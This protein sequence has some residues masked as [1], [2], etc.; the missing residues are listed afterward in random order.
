MIV[1]QFSDNTRLFK[2]RW[3]DRM[4]RSEFNA[5]HLVDTCY[6]TAE[7]M[8]WLLNIIKLK[9]NKILLFLLE[10]LSSLGL[11]WVLPETQLSSWVPSLKLNKWVSLEYFEMEWISREMMSHPTEDGFLSRARANRIYFIFRSVAQAVKPPEP[12][13][14][15]T[16]NKKHFSSWLNLLL[17]TFFPLILYLP[18]KFL[19]PSS[20]RCGLAGRDSQNNFCY[21][22]QDWELCG[23][24]SQPICKSWVWFNVF[25]CFL[26]GTLHL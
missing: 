25:S 21:F 18:V 6:P 22:E 9:I 17:P 3:N 8:F 16:I 24:N 19:T 5:M 13:F 20:F 11:S 2:N 10:L 26:R 15:L 4:T 12:P 14:F 23:T 7:T 1:C